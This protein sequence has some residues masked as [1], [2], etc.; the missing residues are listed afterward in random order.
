[1]YYWLMA[2]ELA[3]WKCLQCFDAVVLASGRASS[4]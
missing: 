2:L 1:M 3:Q 4:L